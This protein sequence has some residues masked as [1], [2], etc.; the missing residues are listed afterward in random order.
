MKKTTKV[1]HIDIPGRIYWDLDADERLALRTFIDKGGLGWN[2]ALDMQDELWETHRGRSIDY[3]RSALEKTGYDVK[4]VLS[5]HHFIR[6]LIKK[7]PS[8]IITRQTS[9]PKKNWLSKIFAGMA[10]KQKSI[11]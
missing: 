5:M 9:S 1:Q 7:D 4:L 3:L 11:D 6:R 10:N 2:A 8:C